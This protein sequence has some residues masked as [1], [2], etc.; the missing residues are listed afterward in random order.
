MGIRRVL[1]AFHRVR[2]VS[3]DWHYRCLISVALHS[4]FRCIMRMS[5]ALQE[6]E[7]FQG[8]FEGTSGRFTCLLVDFGGITEAISDVSEVIMCGTRGPMWLGVSV[9]FQKI[10]EEFQRI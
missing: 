7:M 5:G 6:A 9:A 4:R 1:D 3:W 8:V 2:G 10:S